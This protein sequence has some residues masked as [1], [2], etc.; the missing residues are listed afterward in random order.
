MKKFGTR[1]LEARKTPVQARSA[2][3][4]EAILEATIQVLLEAGPERLTTTRVA[5]RAGASVGTLY[6]YFPNKQSVLYAV[7]EMHLGNVQK[8]VQAACQTVHGEPVERMAEVVAL[9][10]VEAKMKRA[11]A[12]A[13]LYRIA[14]TVET[15]SLVQGVKRRSV[16]ALA[17]MLATARDARFVDVAAVAETL[18]GAMVG[19]VR[20]TLEAGASPKMVKSLREQL[21]VLCAAY[22]VAAGRE[23]N[24]V[25]KAGAAA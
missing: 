14:A 4:V 21:V 10:F 7:L 11:D 24:G 13:A 5:E 12:S 8:A 6:Q 22:L 2:A 23:A 18:Y 15:K 9:A 20:A 3:T 25:R 16:A 1:G 17:K 19:A